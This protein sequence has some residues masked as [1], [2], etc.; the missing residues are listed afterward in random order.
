MAEVACNGLT[1]RFGE[2]TALADVSFKTP[3]AGA[4]LVI[5]PSG[6]GKTTLLRLIAGLDRPDAGTVRIG[7]EA[8]NGPDRMTPPHRRGVAFV[9]QRPSLWP[10]LS[11]A[12]NVALALAARGMKKRERR[13][14]AE[15]MLERLGLN[16][17]ARAYPHT[18]SGGEMQRVGLARALVAEPRVLLL[19]EPFSGL[20]EGLRREIASRL[21]DLKR[22]QGVTL[23]WVTHRADEAEGIADQIVR[24]RAGRME[25][26]KGDGC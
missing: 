1:R 25:G 26:K 22:A 2:V 15:E 14:R 13:A 24:L 9:F 18:L 11:A 7:G 17:R 10:H 12:D 21:S 16:S 23:I 6:S 20:D 8:M 4:C 5:G 3:A 19:D